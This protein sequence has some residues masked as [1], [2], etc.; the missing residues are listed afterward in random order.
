MFTGIIETTAKVMAKTTDS[1]TLERPAMFSDIKEGTSIAVNGACLS[2]V[3]LNNTEL[4]FDI[5]PETWAKTNLGDLTFND[6]V[7]VER[8]LAAAG[9]FE[10]HI[11]QGH[12]EGIATV[13]SLDQP[14]SSPWA[15]LIINVTDAL[16]TYI[17]YKGSIAINGVSLTIARKEN[18][19]I[20][21]ELIPHTL[22]MTNLGVLTP[23]DKVN[24]ETDILARYIE[25]YLSKKS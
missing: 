23:G 7:N 13:I 20:T 11:V 6:T 10:G 17:V 1:L 22:E 21:L 5:M 12:I 4:S 3:R 25:S 18:N 9:R 16:S 8:A 14:G 24:I 2:V 19:L 15:T